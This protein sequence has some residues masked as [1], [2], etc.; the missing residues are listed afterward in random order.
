MI[1]TINIVLI[2]LTFILIVATVS[3][4]KEGFDEF[5]FDNAP[6]IPYIPQDIVCLILL[7]MGIKVDTYGILARRCKGKTTK[8]K[9]QPD[10]NFCP[11]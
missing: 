9:T 11:R 5:D 4:Q 10:T 7:S 3:K 2:I 6:F 1:Y 8:K